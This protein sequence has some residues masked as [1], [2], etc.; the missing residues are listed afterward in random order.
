MA[1]QKFLHSSLKPLDKAP[2]DRVSRTEWADRQTNLFD[3]IADIEA[4]VDEDGDPD[5]CSPYGCRSG[6]SEDGPA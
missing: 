5:G 2:I 3:A 1:G 4:G 6:S